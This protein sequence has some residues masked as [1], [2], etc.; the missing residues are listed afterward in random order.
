MRS[1]PLMTPRYSPDIQRSTTVSAISCSD[2][3]TSDAGRCSA[4][5]QPSATMVD[6]SNITA[7]P[8]SAT[9]TKTASSARSNRR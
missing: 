2:P 9:V 1:N 3:I 5:S 6:A 8:S 7:A 4:R